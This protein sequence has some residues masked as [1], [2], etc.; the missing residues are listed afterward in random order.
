M[1]KE[2][3][4]VFLTISN[5]RVLH[6]K[7]LLEAKRVREC[8]SFFFFFLQHEPDNEWERWRE[9]FIEDQGERQ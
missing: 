4:A 7:S 1:I 6:N 2:Q 5:A 3:G 8:C 9:A